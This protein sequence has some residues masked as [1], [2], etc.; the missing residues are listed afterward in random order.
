MRSLRPGGLPRAGRSPA[1]TTTPARVL[2]AGTATAACTRRGCRPRLRRRAGLTPDRGDGHRPGRCRVLSTTG[3]RASDPAPLA[4]ARLLKAAH[5]IARRTADRVRHLDPHHGGRRDEL[6][7]PDVR[8][9]SCRPDMGCGHEGFHGQAL[10]GRPVHEHRGRGPSGGQEGIALGGRGVDLVAQR[11]ISRVVLRHAE[12]SK[13]TTTH[14]RTRIGDCA[15]PRL[16]RADYD[17]I[18]LPRLAVIQPGDAIR[19]PRDQPQ[20]P[21]GADQLRELAFA[22]EKDAVDDTPTRPEVMLYAP[23]GDELVQVFDAIRLGHTSRTAKVARYLL[24]SPQPYSVA[25]ITGAYRGLDLLP[26]RSTSSARRRLRR[27]QVR[28]HPRPDPAPGT[29]RPAR[30]H[31]PAVRSGRSARPTSPPGRK[32]PPDRGGHGRKQFAGGHGRIECDLLGLA[33]LL[34][35]TLA[36]VKTSPTVIRDWIRAS[37]PRGS[38]VTR[39]FHPSPSVSVMPRYCGSCSFIPLFPFVIP[40]VLAVEFEGWTARCVGEAGVSHKA[41]RVCAASQGACGSGLHRSVRSTPGSEGSRIV[42]CLRARTASASPTY[43]MAT[44]AGWSATKTVG[45]AKVRS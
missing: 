32:R 2:L 16:R 25:G 44:W 19:Q 18:T 20:P 6:V 10:P 14:P 35:V 42:A 45:P 34:V 43:G 8:A 3:K 21:G 36:E 37:S 13:P 17:W 30:A 41:A 5:Q 31:R 27:Q 23:L 4:G 22:R 24:R 12:D 15:I 28:P 38:C 11:G 1:L 29:Q 40:P 7:R 26:P 39:I 33:R 9:Q